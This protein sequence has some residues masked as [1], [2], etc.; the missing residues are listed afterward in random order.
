MIFKATSTNDFSK[1]LKENLSLG[2]FAK[3]LGD[4]ELKILEDHE[5]KRRKAVVS[6]LR[7]IYT[8]SFVSS[9]T[10]TDQEN[11]KGSR[12]AAYTSGE[13]TRQ[14]T[15]KVKYRHNCEGESG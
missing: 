11:E 13:P 5:K 6:I 14:N 7:A 3:E 8:N 4:S 10:A 2:A 9:N 12:E 15:C 1:F